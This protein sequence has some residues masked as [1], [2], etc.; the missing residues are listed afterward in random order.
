M[1]S[2]AAACRPSFMLTPVDMRAILGQRFFFFFFPHLSFSPLP[3][4]LC[5]LFYFFMSL[6][7]FS[8]PWYSH[9]QAT[10]ETYRWTHMTQMNVKPALLPCQQLGPI[11]LLL[12]LTAISCAFERT[13]KQQIGDNNTKK[14]GNI[15]YN[16]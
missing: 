7:C 12:L 15:F 10:N 2:H 9:T 5:R 16:I 13:P 6:G 1:G 8:R 4:S 11:L 14:T 3:Y